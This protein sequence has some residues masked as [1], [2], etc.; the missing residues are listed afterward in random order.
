MTNFHELGALRLI[1]VAVLLHASPALATDGY[2]LH[3]IGAKAKGNA[4][5]AIALPQE[6][7]AIATNPAS[8]TQV[9][10]RLD[11]GMDIFIPRRDAQIE[12][13]QAGLDG[14]YDGNGAN[15][16]I[17]G[18][19]AYVRPLSDR[20]SVGLVVYANGGMNSVYERNPFAAFGASGDAG[21]DLKQGFVVPTV[22]YEVADRH[23]LG[24]SAV[25]LVQSFRA[26]GIQPFAAF[27]VE[28][29][30]FTN[31]GDDWSVGAGFKIGYLG[32]FGDR[33]S[34]GAFYQSEIHA[35][36]F[37]KYAGLFAEG[38]NFNVPASWGVG[39]A[40]EVN[41][42]LT[43][44]ADFKRIEYNGVGSVGNSISRLL[45]G[46]PFGSEGG[47][48]FGWRDISVVK[49][50]AVWEASDT[51]TLRA[52]YGRS[53]NPVPESET[54]VN[55]ISPGVVEDHLTVGATVNLNDRV[56]LTAHALVA[57][58]NEVEGRGSI[59]PAFGGGEADIAL[60]EVSLGFAL[61]FDF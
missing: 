38:G 15:P 41:D 32:R 44:A 8:A 31:R 11:I 21:V 27:S 18:D 40:A 25:G 36:P 28:P 23:S 57:P 5:V 10:H 48:G 37:D 29:E 61:G 3:G 51:V 49:V 58:R 45:D 46:R 43:V 33:M 50:G 52:G 34:I 13:N 4:G 54:L 22:A 1:G 12:G 6:A 39:V 20:V 55:V 26:Y 35:E 2:F 24:F 59:A 56:D 7:T 47:P 42:R 14:E 19:I 9:D 16:F 60:S 17:L 30:N 53:E